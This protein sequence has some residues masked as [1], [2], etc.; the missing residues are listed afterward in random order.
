MQVFH[1]IFLK[2]QLWKL[3]VEFVQETLLPYFFNRLLILITIEYS[4]S[5]SL[6][7]KIE[8]CFIARSF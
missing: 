5:N 2:H 8:H 1:T 3:L 7:V 4:S 6:N